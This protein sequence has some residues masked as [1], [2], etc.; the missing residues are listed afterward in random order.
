MKKICYFCNTSRMEIPTRTVKYQLTRIYHWSIKYVGSYVI[1][2]DLT[3]NVFSPIGLG[4]RVT[5]HS[6]KQGT[7]ENVHVFTVGIRYQGRLPMSFAG[8]VSRTSH[9]EFFICR[10]DGEFGDYQKYCFCNFIWDQFV[11]FAR[12]H[13]R[14][15]LLKQCFW[16]GPDKDIINDPELTACYDALRTNIGLL[17][18]VLLIPGQGFSTPDIAFTPVGHLFQEQRLNGLNT[19][20]EFKAF[21]DNDFPTEEE[22]DPTEDLFGSF[23]DSFEIDF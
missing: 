21:T 7:P 17:W 1:N 12:Y 2:E 3:R 22:T 5:K 11:Y 20:W 10:C 14:S 23:T 8:S 4:G 19:Q 9:K 13:S 6:F 18:N 16:H 15:T